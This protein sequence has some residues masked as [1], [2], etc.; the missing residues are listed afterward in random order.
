[1]AGRFYV[2][3]N[4]LVLTMLEDDVQT[5]PLHGEPE[6]VGKFGSPEYAR[7]AAEEWLS[8]QGGATPFRA[9]DGDLISISYHCATVWEDVLDN[10]GVPL[11]CTATG[12]LDDLTG[13]LRAI[14]DQRVAEVKRLYYGDEDDLDGYEDDCLGC[15]H[16][17]E[18]GA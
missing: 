13:E 2:D 18:R 15:R 7:R 8:A 9:P 5:S 10:D 16:M 17:S 4:E 11:E 1:M 3:G 14:W 12:Y 6:Y